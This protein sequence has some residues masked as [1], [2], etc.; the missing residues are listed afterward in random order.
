MNT[1]DGSYLAEFLLEKGYEVHGIVRRSSSFN[2]GRIEHLYKNPQAHIE[3]NMKLHYGDLTDS[4]CLVKIINE[5]KPSEIYNLGAQSH[6]KLSWVI[7][8]L[9]LLRGDLYLLEKYLFILH[10]YELKLMASHIQSRLNAVMNEVVFIFV[11]LMTDKVPPP[12]SPALCVVST[13][14]LCDVTS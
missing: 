13:G 2:T 3:G 10:D 1:Q 9:S 4:T 12:S 7:E 8:N 5:V 11:T 14:R 6:V